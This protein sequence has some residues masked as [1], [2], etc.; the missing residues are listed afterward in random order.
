MRT[1][2]TLQIWEAAERVTEAVKADTPNT[3]PEQE[4]AQEVIGQIES[5]TT[6]LIQELI[7]PAIFPFA[8]EHILVP[9]VGFI[10]VVGK[11]KPH[12]KLGNRV[13]WNRE[14]DGDE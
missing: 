13:D 3:K 6:D 11:I 2:T 12:K 10:P 1:F 7:T 5:V 9:S 14:G 8:S 4:A